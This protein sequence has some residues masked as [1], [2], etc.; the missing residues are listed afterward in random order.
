MSAS[1]HALLES[2]E[3]FTCGEVVVFHPKVFQNKNY[4]PHYDVYK[5]HRFQIVDIHEEFE[6]GLPLG[7]P[8]F[9]LTCVTGSVQVKGHVH[10]DELK[11]AP[12]ESCDWTAF[13]VIKHLG[14]IPM[15]I[16]TKEGEAPRPPSDSEVR[17]WLDQSAVIINGK[18]P[19]AKDIVEWPITQLVFF[20]KSE[21]KRTTVI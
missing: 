21:K 5:G 11:H 14:V 2:H 17:R 10:P 6:D 19:K 16:E 7:E 13:E 12:V 20:P 18:R 8:H 3:G 1:N 15:S 4:V 9:E